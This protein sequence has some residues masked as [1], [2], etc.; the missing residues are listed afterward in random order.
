VD[1]RTEKRK[2]HNVTIVQG[3]DARC[4]GYELQKLADFF[5]K[6]FSVATFLEEMGSAT[7][8]VVGGFF[9]RDLEE[10][11]A[12]DLGVPTDCVENLAAGRKAD[13]K[14]RKK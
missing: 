9:D 14:Q 5:K 8:I 3:L 11:I 7:F 13:M 4:Y 10:I 1:I 2:N 6:K 12:K